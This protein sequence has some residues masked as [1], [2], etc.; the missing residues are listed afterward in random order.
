MIAGILGMIELAMF[1]DAM[2][3]WG[4]VFLKGNGDEERVRKITSRDNNRY[5]IVIEL[6]LV[7][8]VISP[9]QL[10]RHLPGAKPGACLSVAPEPTD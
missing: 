2:S 6:S 1:N 10:A 8:P 5:A 7:S 4:E 9:F 3:N